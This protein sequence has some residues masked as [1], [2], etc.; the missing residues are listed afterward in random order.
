MGK[1]LFFI[2][3][4]LVWIYAP[5]TRRVRA[6]IIRDGKILV[7]KNWFG[8]GSWQLPGGGI[9]MGES[10]LDAGARE[11]KEELGVNAKSTKE[12]HD[13][14][15]I[16]KQFGLLMRYHFIKVELDDFKAALKLN[17]E[18]TNAQWQDLDDKKML[19]PEVNR[20]LS[21]VSKM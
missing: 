6:V 5:V 18:I 3:W 12:L 10:V 13:G 20:G 16:H 11:L 15:V 19:S 8:P 14:F 2:L 4:P 9:K 7:V 1:I 21:L 17:R